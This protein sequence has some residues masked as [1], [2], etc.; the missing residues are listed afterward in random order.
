MGYKTLLDVALSNY[1]NEE[2]MLDEDYGVSVVLIESKMR[3]N[4]EKREFY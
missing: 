2:N 3:R 4:Q 1:K